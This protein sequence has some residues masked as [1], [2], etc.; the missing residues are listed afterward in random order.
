MSNI[1]ENLFDAVKIITSSM[2]SSLQ[3]DKTVIAKIAD[4]SNAARGEYVVTDGTS[5]YTAYSEN[6]EYQEGTSVYVNILN[7][8]YSNQKFIIGR[9]V[10]KEDNGYFNYVSPMNKFVDITGDI[11]IEGNDI[12]NSIA[13]NGKDDEIVIYESETNLQLRGFDRLG[14]SAEFMTTGLEKIK[15]GDYGLKI[16]AISKENS[17][18]FKYVTMVFN[19][20]FGNPYQFN[21]YFLQ[22]GV[23]DISEEISELY[24]FK[25][26]LYQDSNFYDFDNSL[27]NH[28]NANN[29]IEAKKK[30]QN[31]IKELFAANQTS[32]EQWEQ[33]NLYQEL[34]KDVEI[35]SKSE[36]IKSLSDNIFIRDIQVRLGYDLDNFKE[37]A[38]KA[39]V[40]TFD[41]LSY[42]KYRPFNTKTLACR[43]IQNIDNKII[44]YSKIEDLPENSA[45]KWYK[46]NNSIWEE[47]DNNTF[48]IKFLPQ[49]DIIEEQIK[50]IVETPGK[51]YLRNQMEAETNITQFEIELN[52]LEIG[53]TEY[54]L[55]QDE[56]LKINQDYYQN[57]QNV[58][59][60]IIT[61]KNLAPSISSAALEELNS[62]LTLTCDN[63]GNFLLYNTM[64]NNII[65]NSA[66]NTLRYIT[67]FYNGKKEDITKIK[68]CIPKSDTMIQ[69]PENGKEYV[70][71]DSFSEDDKY[72][73]IERQ[74]T[75]GSLS[76]QQ[77]IRL[78]PSLNQK[79][80]N[81]EVVCFISNGKTQY[82]Q[83]ITLTFGYAGS[84]GTN[85]T[86]NLELE[87]PITIG[88]EN[89]VEI[90]AKLYDKENKLI[91]N[92][93]NRD[94]IFSWYSQDNNN[95]IVFCDNLGERKENQGYV[96]SVNDYGGVAHCYIKNTNG[97]FGYYYILQARVKVGLENNN[98]VTL[99][100][101]LPIPC[102]L[103]ESYTHL[104]GYDR[105]IYDGF[106][107][108]VGDYSTKYK[109]NYIGDSGGEIIYGIL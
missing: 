71:T 37:D 74:R 7:G 48:E 96:S 12:K 25:V 70:D 79:A 102:R 38:A 53:S 100:S 88:D 80:L 24:Y 11:C 57:A 19:D 21:T 46:N 81:N 17:G 94:I 63:N 28:T 61:F 32:Q 105:I 64:T 6:T 49:Y 75:D 52:S 9:Y 34:V 92:C 103:D 72:Y 89:P 1:S 77:G 82:S 15:T 83:K 73:Y 98:S 29:L 68:W 13:A 107:K 5:T 66:A 40:Y 76:L 85:Y 104:E 10:S 22:E 26:V 14:I 8:D 41:D 2:I 65:N 33:D 23:F 99:T 51:E 27:F 93:D 47:I 106:G 54:A 42:S 43:F 50:V 58:E 36:N 97:E 101:Y 39:I 69:T 55:K 35:Y 87:S 78:K 56:I 18:E 4:A 45:I 109:I 90:I 86:L 31:R 60:N 91:Q 59:S 108:K 62:T 30:L 44:S 3:F 67:A 16:Y 20:F 95:T 84:S